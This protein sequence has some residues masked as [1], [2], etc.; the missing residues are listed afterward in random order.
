VSQKAAW[1]RYVEERRSELHDAYPCAAP[2]RRRICP[3]H[4]V[5]VPQETYVRRKTLTGRRY[6]KRVPLSGI[7]KR[8]RDAFYDQLIT[9]YLTKTRGD[10]A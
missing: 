1:R 4:H 8:C 6:T 2:T 3:Q 10:N 7:C 9:E 5:R